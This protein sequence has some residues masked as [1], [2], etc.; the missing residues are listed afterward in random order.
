MTAS[1]NK[2]KTK[3]EEEIQMKNVK[4]RVRLLVVPGPSQSCIPI[5]GED[6]G[7]LVVRNLGPHC[8]LLGMNCGDSSP[9]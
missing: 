4:N 3:K 1:A 7:N 5:L 9:G 2:S 8:L 6:H